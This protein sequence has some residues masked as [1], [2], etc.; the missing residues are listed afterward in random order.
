MLSHVLLS[1]IML[2]V[3]TPLF[4]PFWWV[5]LCWNLLYYVII[6]RIAIIQGVRT[7]L[8]VVLVS[9][10]MLSLV[11]LS[12]VML[13]VKPPLSIPF[14]RVS[15]CWVLLYCVVNVLLFKVSQNYSLCCS[16]ECLYA[17]SCYT[18]CRYAES[19]YTE[20]RY[21]ECQGTALSALKK[22]NYFFLFSQ[23]SLWACQIK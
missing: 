18:K 4:M 12:V 21:A 13:S 8:N 20:C 10:I 14:W 5:S 6:M 23:K 22:L 17:E 2:S 15:L 9:V 1:V 16:G 11:I 19:F 7:T 3:K